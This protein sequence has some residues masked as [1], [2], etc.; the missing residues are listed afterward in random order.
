MK[1]YIILGIILIGCSRKESEVKFEP[2]PVPVQVA[3]VEVRDVPLY[4]TAQGVI[5]PS[6]YVEV[7]PQVKGMLKKVHFTEGE[8]VEEGALL[9]SI[10]EGTYAIRVQEI[11]AQIDQDFAHLDNAKKTLARYQSLTKRD[12]ISQVDWDE[13]KTKV[14]LHEAMLKANQARLAAALLDLE[15]CQVRAPIAGY[16]GKSSLKEGNMVE[17]PTTLVHLTQTEPLLVDFTITEQELSH[18]QEAAPIVEVYAL[19]KEERLAVGKVTFMDHVIDAKTGMLAVSGTLTEV[20]KPLWPGQTVRIHLYFGTKERAVLVPMRAIKTNQ[21]GPYLFAV[22]DDQTVEI[23]AL[24]LGPEE[25]GQIVIEEG[26]EGVEKVITEGH[27]RLFP[28]SK[29]EEIR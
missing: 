23:R 21:E 17:S 8:W 28:G 29:I 15:H 26:L 25:K 13:L 5:K 2:P 6:S 19:G 14:A 27:L 9:Y 18:I 4:F 12:L 3:S 10:E 11:E 1:Q 24:K 22:K 16:A 7:K 20:Q